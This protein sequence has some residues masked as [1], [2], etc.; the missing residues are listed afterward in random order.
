MKI[1]A[2][3][4]N[5]AEQNCNSVCNDPNSTEDERITAI[6]TYLD[7]EWESSKEKRE[8]RIKILAEREQ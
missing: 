8:F 2:R 4:L 3:M 7:M 6:S 5:E 1:T